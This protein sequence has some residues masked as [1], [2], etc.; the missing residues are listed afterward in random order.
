MWCSNHRVFPF[1][2]VPLLLSV[3]A[4]SPAAD[5]QTAWVKWIVD[6]DTL[7]LTNGG[8]IRLI[9]MDISEAYESNKYYRDVERRGRDVKTMRLKTGSAQ[10]IQKV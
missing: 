10:L 7:L 4:F 3:P 1:L 5:F 6:G 8:R 2:F 9:S